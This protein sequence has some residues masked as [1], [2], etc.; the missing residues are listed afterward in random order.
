MHMAAWLQRHSNLPIS[1]VARRE[2]HHSDFLTHGINYS[3]HKKF[4][5]MSIRAYISRSSLKD[6]KNLSKSKIS[7]LDIIFFIGSRSIKIDLDFSIFWAR[8]SES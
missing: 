7:N 1:H 3:N 4:K 5:N 6:V 8:M 2:M